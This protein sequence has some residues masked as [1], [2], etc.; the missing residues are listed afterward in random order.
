MIGSM[1]GVEPD[2]TDPAVTIPRL[3]ALALVLVAAVTDMRMRRVPNVLTFPAAAL[4]LV[5]GGGLGG[6]R[7]VAL[8]LAGLGAG[9]GLLLLPFAWRLIHGGDVKL[10]GAAGAFLGPWGALWAFLLA[11]VFGGL[12]ALAM[13]IVTSR[14]RK[15]LPIWWAQVKNL[16]LTRDLGVLKQGAEKDRIYLPYAVPIA[17]GT[18]AAILT[19]GSLY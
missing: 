1:M 11:S 19:E 8:S 18:V 3:C 10:L 13:L 2:W 7:G 6:L 5:L 9:I 4:G 16:A 15:K 12:L 17:L 14:G